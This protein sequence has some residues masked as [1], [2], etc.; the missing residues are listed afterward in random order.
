MRLAS[1][2]RLCIFRTLIRSFSGISASD[3]RGVVTITVEYNGATRT[4]TYSL[5]QY[6]NST[7]ADVAK[8]LYSY[9][10]AAAAYKGISKSEQK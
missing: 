6:I 4:V 8:A 9:S 7:D 1:V 2:V 10:K 3:V 5:A